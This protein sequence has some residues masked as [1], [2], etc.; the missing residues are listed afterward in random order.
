MTDQAMTSGEQELLTSLLKAVSRSFYLTLRVLPRAVRSQIGLAYLLA[1]A[2]DTIADTTL[3]PVSQ[4]LEALAALRHRILGQS[5]GRFTFEVSASAVDNPAELKLLQRIEEALG[6]LAGNQSADQAQIRTVLETITSGQILDL[7]RFGGASE[8]AIV[9]LKTDAELD[10]YTYRV[11]GCV[12][13]FW[14]H[15]CRGHLFP[16]VPL[17]EGRLLQQ[18]VRFGKGLQLVNILRDLP[19]DLR[20]GRCYLPQDR[21]QTIGLR[22]S[23][24]LDPNREKTLRPLYVQ[25]L[26]LAHEHLAAGWEYTNTVPYGQRRVRLACAWPILIGIKT[27]VKLRANP[28]LAT[29]SCV[30]VSRNEV[31]AV[32][33]ST[34]IRY[35]FPKL[36]Q[37]LFT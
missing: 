5:T 13:E 37:R 25:Y 29:N 3:V 31:R 18:G 14:T 8:S 26:D 10:D 20:N 2:T 12:G 32:L 6:L 22:P 36:W 17:D 16:E 9:A 1:R 21:L 35:P 19:K 7:Q 30:K 15:L 24:L 28:I 4:R 11:A 33:F 23:D 27:L 34:L